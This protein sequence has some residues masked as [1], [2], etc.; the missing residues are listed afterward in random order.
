MVTFLFTDIEGSTK[1]WE[2]HADE[3][4]VALARHDA[5]MREAI[6][7]ANGL[8]FKTV[9]D[10]FCAVF[11]L[12]S[13]AVAAALKVQMALEAEPWPEAT[14]IKVRLALHTGA[15]ASREGD[16]FGATLNRVAR[17][18]A[19]GHG[20]QT[21]VSQ[22]TYDLVGD[23]LPA[24]VSLRDLGAHQ[25]KDLARP[26][27]VYQLQHPRLHGDFPPIKSL[28]TH[29]NNLPQQL[30]SFIGREKELVEIRSLL[31]K[32]RLLTLTGSG[33]SG[34]TR[35]SL[36]LGAD[37]LE[38]FPDG[39][40]LVELAPLADPGL[41]PQTVAS[42]L[43][44]KEEPGKPILQTLTEHLKTRRLLLLLDNCEHMVAACAKV[45]DTLMRQCPG[46]KI[47][48]TS[49]EAL[50]IAG[51]QT[52]AVPALT[53]P[54]RKQAHT[55]ASLSQYESVQLFSARALLVRADFR[56]TNQNASAVASLCFQLDGI[57]LAIELAAARLRSLSVDEINGKLDQRFRLLTGGSRTALPRQQT[58]RSLID[59]SYDL[60]NDS[61]RLLLQ[62]LSA[63]AGGWTLAAAE[64]VC[65][66]EGVE[67]WEVLDLST[68]L[69]DKSLVVAEQKNERSRYR[70]LE[71]VRQYAQERLVERGGSE[72]LRERH[73]DYFLALAEEAEP[74]LISAERSE[75][76]KV[77]DEEHENL[78]AGLDWS[79]V[80]A[81]SSAGLRLCGALTRFWQMRGFLAEGR[82]WCARVLKKPAGVE[83]APERAKALN[84]AGLLAFAHSDYPE[85]RSRFE[86][87]LAIRRQLDD[88]RGTAAT[89]NNL[90]NVALEQGDFATARV[91]YEESREIARDLG[92]RL[93]MVVALNSLGRVTYEQG[94]HSAA[95][96]L[97]EESLVIVRELG[98]RS[99]LGILLTNLG[100][101]VSEQGDY[102]SATALQAE[103]LAIHREA[104]NRIGVA[105]TLSNIADRV[106][107]QGDFRAAAALHKEGLMIQRE[108]GDRRGIA[109][110]MV[111]L[112]A[113]AAAFGNPLRAARMWGAAEQMREDVGSPLEP[114]DRPRYDRRLA[115]ARVAVGDGA[116]FDRAWQEG[117]ALTLER[118][119]ELALE[120]TVERG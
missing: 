98:D 6:V 42:E 120:E 43:G 63:F 2:A 36:Q 55:P 106:A 16:Y 26:E 95:R 117:R 9:G 80:E 5:L 66:G 24:A 41:A 110:S 70:L 85:A 27:Q 34:K 78:Q 8:V 23:T 89:L 118:A 46:V 68:S 81:G 111:G 74:K 40:W 116:A 12:A 113:G 44:V 60:L 94:E 65:A 22:A 96:R 35:L 62:R 51:E 18:L 49:R 101:V 10:A 32:T 103:A 33:G 83:R 73:R 100:I 69:S 47:L 86:E 105:I 30:T 52:Y 59:W 1:L 91:L 67:D 109:Y 38:Q 58:L 50:G 79:V 71:T 13:D 4:Q 104:G 90:G 45:A 61:E 108:L 102:D 3:M 87:S 25:L 31:G 7:G 15:A 107:K 19:T 37:S 17:L 54:N 72:A 76:M 115:N 11:A 84:A 97:Y 112:A 114:K 56:I 53:L 75:W 57:P 48:A 21:L 29:P 14:R 119:I 39:A 77:L 82:E 64:Q 20:G 92:D 28:S 88:R 99:L 93:S